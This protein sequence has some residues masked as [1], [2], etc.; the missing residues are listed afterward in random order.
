MPETEQFN[1]P[2]ERTVHKTL[3]ANDGRMEQEDLLESVDA[4][5]HEVLGALKSMMQ[6]NEVSYGVEWDLVLEGYDSDADTGPGSPAK[7]HY[8][9]EAETQIVCEEGH[10]PTRVKE[11]EGY[12][13]YF[14]PE[15]GMIYRVK[16]D[17]HQT[18]RHVDL[19]EVV[20]VED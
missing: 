3:E 6:R 5:D 11:R 15:C 12:T 10:P 7:H 20:P 18:D 8:G 17:V 13:Q 2:I 1:D 4:E 16:T 19:D 9:Y 14:C